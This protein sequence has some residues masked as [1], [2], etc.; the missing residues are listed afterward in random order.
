MTRAHNPEDICAHCDEYSVRQAA[1]EYA[2]IG[3]GKCLV[4]CEN[5]PLAAHVSWDRPACVSFRLDRRNIV[6]R[7]QYV[8]VQ[9]LNEQQEARQ[10]SPAC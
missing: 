2:D 7:R 6:A 8:Q 1:P 4:Q 9:R 10:A 3:M 5:P